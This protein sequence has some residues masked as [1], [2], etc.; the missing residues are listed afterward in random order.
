MKHQLETSL[1]TISWSKFS[2]PF[3]SIAFASMDSYNQL[4]MKNVWGNTA[5]VLNTYRLFPSHY[6][7]SNKVEQLFIY[8]SYCIQYS[9]GLEFKAHM[10]MYTG[11]M[12]IRYHFI[13]RTWA[14]RDFMS[15]GG[16]ESNPWKQW[17]MTA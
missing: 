16:T 11:D 17:L 9:R 13:Q 2:Q 12:Q 5:F 14:S 15:V 8:H 7:L 10:K 3:L 6:S 1:L 4:Q